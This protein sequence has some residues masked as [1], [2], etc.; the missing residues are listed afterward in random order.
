MAS[1]DTA[2]PRVDQLLGCAFDAM[3]VVDRRVGIV[4][5][6]GSALQLLGRTLDEV[7]GRNAGDF[8]GEHPPTRGISP[9][10][11]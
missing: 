11:A 4:G 9:R 5:A 6:N 1:C 10:I 8:I 2:L 3:L 7:F